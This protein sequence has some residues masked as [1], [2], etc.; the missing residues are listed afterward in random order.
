[1]SGLGKAERLLQLAKEQSSDKRRQLLRE[2][3]DIFLISPES[4]TASEQEHFGEIISHVAQ[5]ADAQAR[6]YLAERLADVKVAPRK[7]VKQLINDT[8]GI[9]RPLLERNPSIV[10]SDLI[11]VIRSKNVAYQASIARRNKLDASVSDALVDNGAADAVR[12]LIENE[13]AH[14]APA[15][16]EKAVCRSEREAVLQGPLVARSDVPVELLQDMFWFVSP[17]L[18][19][20]IVA[21]SAGTDS[22]VRRLPYKKSGEFVPDS[23]R[24]G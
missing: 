3:T 1:M 10:D 22:K 11:E 4:Y 6:A 12:V 18:R 24:P 2:I 13:T 5:A 16:M 20:K 7:I 15:T 23:G 17:G 21:A 9:A 19:R 8:I 14:I